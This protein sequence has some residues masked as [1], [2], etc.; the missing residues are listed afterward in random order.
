MSWREHVVLSWAGMRGVDSLAAALAL[1]LVTQ[2]GAPFPNRALI[3]FMTFSVILATLVLQGLSLKPLILWLGIVDDSS[4]QEEERKAR[5]QANQAGLAKLAEVAKQRPVEE[6]VLGRLRAEYEERI[7][8]LG[9]P[10]SSNAPAKLSLFA[11]EYEELLREILGE[12]RKTILRLRNERAIN[13]HVL[14]RI[15]RD[16][17]LAEARLQQGDVD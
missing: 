5:L 6:S 10:E 13:D 9:A 15:Q 17:D 16:I 2:N 11:P 12:E 14:R 8:Q 1:P 7:E 3:V 4:L